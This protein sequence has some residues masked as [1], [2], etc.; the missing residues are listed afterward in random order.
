MQIRFELHM[1]LHV[2]YTFDYIMGGNSAKCGTVVDL[3]VLKDRT[4]SLIHTCNVHIMHKA[5]P[6]GM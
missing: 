2:K 3:L 4:A 5:I 1:T 6:T